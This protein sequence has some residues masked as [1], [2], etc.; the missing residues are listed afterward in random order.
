ML[1]GTRDARDPGR[2]LTPVGH[3][4]TR[5]EI[6][7]LQMDRLRDAIVQVTTEDGFEN[8]GIKVICSRAGVGL[9]SFYEHF[10]SKNQLILAAYDEGVSVLF[11]AV[12]TAYNEPPDGS[13]SRERTE[14]GILA[15]LEILAENPAFAKFFLVEFH[16]GGPEAQRRVEDALEAAYQL[17]NGVQPESGL[18]GPDPEMVPMLV[19]GIYSHL[20]RQ[21]RIG[22]TASL[23]ALLPGLMKFSQAVI[24][25][26]GVN[27][28]NLR[29][30]R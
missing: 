27:S 26:A 2:S 1:P 3:G 21:V 5:Q 14:V 16:K 4:Y 25:A 11:D 10:H 12:S 7:D 9:A 30:P 23:P 13:A 18:M 6:A 8:A 20:S 28:L 17:F 22:Q 29:P 15:L 24:G 19:G